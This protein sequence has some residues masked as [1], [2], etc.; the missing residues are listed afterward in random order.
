MFVIPNSTNNKPTTTTIS[1]DTN[2][3]PPMHLFL[4]EINAKFEVF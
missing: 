1:I 4:V 2:I 3:I